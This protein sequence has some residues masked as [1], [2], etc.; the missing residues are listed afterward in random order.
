MGFLTGNP[1]V[2][3][4]AN[5]ERTRALMHVTIGTNRAADI[6]VLLS[7]IEDIV[8]EDWFTRFQVAGVNASTRPEVLKQLGVRLH[9]TLSEARFD[10]GLDAVQAALQRPASPPDPTPVLSSVEAYLGSTE[11]MVVVTAEEAHTIAEAVV[12]LGPSPTPEGIDSA[13]A[14]AL[15]L[16]V[17]DTNVADIGWSV[18]TP[19][20]EA[21]ADAQ[22]QAA[23][24]AIANGLNITLNPS[25]SARLS[26]TLLDR[27]V[28]TVGM[29]DGQDPAVMKYTVS[30]LPVM[31]RGLSRSVTA[32]QFKSLGFAMGLV[33]IIL[34]VAF[35]S[36][37]VGLLATAPTA[38]TLLIIYGTMGG[39]G[40]SLDIGTSMLASLIIGAGVDYAVHVLSAW[41]GHDD[42][43]IGCAAL[44]STARV[45]PA[46]WTNAVMVAVGFFVLTLGE[47]RPLKN[48][49]TLTAAAMLVAAA[50]TFLV[51]PLLARR[52]RY[53]LAPEPTDPSDV[54]IPDGLL[55][56]KHRRD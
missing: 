43:P 16:S 33:A 22:A 54:Y 41:Y 45:G 34:S 37:R 6:D 5:E 27:N 31:H 13:V 56:L 20:D 32:N 28:E 8:A 12:G 52:R 38:L 11:A 17:E 44:R 49:G 7:A 1:A 15:N 21:W 29:A 30:G 55:G 39:L 51:I 50:V 36:L 9:R 25:L 48:V 2:R 3:Q 23:L 10:L 14:T 24:E 53:G 35:R 42:E 4:L 40:I 46:V 19:L 26:T 47:A 18:G